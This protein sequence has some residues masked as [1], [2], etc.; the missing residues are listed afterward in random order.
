MP[1]SGDI[2]LDSSVVI[3]FLKGDAALRAHFLS[4]Q[5]LYF[6]KSSSASFIAAPT[7]RAN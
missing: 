6:H 3:P 1:A 7:C 4:S 2:L 5:S